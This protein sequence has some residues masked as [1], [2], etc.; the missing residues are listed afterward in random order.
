MN[1]EQYTL[2]INKSATYRMQTHK[3]EKKHE[4]TYLTNNS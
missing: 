4:Q 2:F 3:N 1:R